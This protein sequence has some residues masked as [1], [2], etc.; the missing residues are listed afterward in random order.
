MSKSSQQQEKGKV[1]HMLAPLLNT[2]RAFHKLFGKFW[3]LVLFRAT[4]FVSSNLL[5]SEQFLYL[6]S[7]SQISEQLLVLKLAFL[8]YFTRSFRFYW[9]ITRFG[10]IY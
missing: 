9:F 10:L 2:G 8:P 1:G 6:C 4:F 3:Q 5:H 7:N